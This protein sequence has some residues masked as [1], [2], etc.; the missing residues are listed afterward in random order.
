IIYVPV[1]AQGVLGVGAT[2]SGLILMP[3]MLG[4]IVLGIVSGYLVTLTGRYKELMLLG[5]VI[6]GVGLWLLARLGVDSTEWQLTGVIAVMGVGLGLASQQYTL[7]VQNAV[8]RAQL[9]VAT[10][11]LQFFRN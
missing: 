11:A 3:M 4:M 8:P 6:L 5:T 7:V 2:A 1:Y 9:G 10:S